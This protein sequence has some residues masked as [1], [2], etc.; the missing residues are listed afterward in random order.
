MQLDIVQKLSS[1]FFVL[2]DVN[3]LSNAMLGV[4]GVWPTLYV[5]LLCGGLVAHIAWSFFGRFKGSD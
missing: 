1:S 2:C 4:Q 3:M 5:F